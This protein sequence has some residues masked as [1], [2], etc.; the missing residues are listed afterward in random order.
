MFVVGFRI[1]ICCIFIAIALQRATTWSLDMTINGIMI[2]LMFKFS[3]NYYLKI[4]CCC[5][6][7]CNQTRINRIISGT[8]IVNITTTP[9][10][11]VEF[12]T[13]KISTTSVT[14]N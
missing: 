9:T 4:F 6:N 3:K 10:T 11:S 7:C 13:E 14:V 8:D 1:F 12:G 5:V 2:I